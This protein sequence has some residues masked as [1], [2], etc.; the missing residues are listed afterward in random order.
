MKHL[1]PNGSATQK[2]YLKIQVAFFLLRAGNKPAMC[3]VSAFQPLY[4]PIQKR[5]K[6]TPKRSSALNSPVMVLQ[7]FCAKR[8]CSAK[9]SSW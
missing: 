2:G 8:K 7:A 3:G 9:S 5:L 6:I 4:L 1:I